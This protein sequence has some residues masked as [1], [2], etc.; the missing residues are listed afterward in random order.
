MSGKVPFSTTADATV[1]FAYYPDFQTSSAYRMEAEAAAQ[2]AMNN[3]LALK[4]GYL[5]RFANQPVPT[6]K[7]NDGLATASLILRWRSAASAP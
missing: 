3:R 6:F 2:A 1:R 5:W 7:K 4:L